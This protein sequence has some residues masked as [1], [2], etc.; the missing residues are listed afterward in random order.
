[1][2]LVFGP[3]E[4]VNR[5]RAKE[6]SGPNEPLLLTDRQVCRAG[7][8][9]PICYSAFSF[10][11][12]E[13]L[14]WLLE[15]GVEVDWQPDQTSDPYQYLYINLINRFRPGCI[16]L[17][18]CNLLHRNIDVEP[19]TMLFYGCSHTRGGWWSRSETGYPY[20]V[21]MRL[22]RPYRVMSRIP[23]GSEILGN[24]H[25]FNLLAN[26][27]FC[28]GQIVVFQLTDLTRI[29]YYDDQDRIFRTRKLDRLPMDH[30]LKIT[31]HQLLAAVFE[32]LQLVLRYVRAKNLQFVFF[33]LS[34][35]TGQK[36][37]ALHNLLEYYLSKFPEFIPGMLDLV[38]DRA[39]D[40]KHF[41]AISNSSFADQ[42]V[43]KIKSLYQS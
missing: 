40:N 6:L 39:D 14:T 5:A 22:N 11:T 4:A 41:G 29:R 8:Q 3:N 38:T 7:L 19:D 30:V 13:D 43:Q 16:D 33:N 9:I 10:L 15:Q 17:D 37:N 31:D 24:Y 42:I 20:Q 21:S 18:P 28:P 27:D 12:V 23:Q 1:M 35:S 36:D 34:G 26:T 2:I 32:H 25:N